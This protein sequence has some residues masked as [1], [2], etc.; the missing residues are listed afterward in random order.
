MSL[1][2]PNGL[3]YTFGPLVRL[4]LVRLTSMP[5]VATCAGVGHERLKPANPVEA[6]LGHETKRCIELARAL[7]GPMRPEYSEGTNGLS[8]GQANDV[9]HSHR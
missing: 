3:T 6:A 5:E 7:S 8:V 1:I 9:V 2:D 4:S